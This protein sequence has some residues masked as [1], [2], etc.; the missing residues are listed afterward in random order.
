MYMS[1]YGKLDSKVKTRESRL[2]FLCPVLTHDIMLERPHP[3]FPWLCFLC[4]PKAKPMCFHPNLQLCTSLIHLKTKIT[5]ALGLDHSERPWNA[6]T[7]PDRSNLSS[8]LSLA[9]ASL[10]SWRI[11]LSS[12]LQWMVMTA[13][14]D[15]MKKK[16][17]KRKGRKD[18]A[19]GVFPLPWEQNP[20]YSDLEFCCL[21]TWHGVQWMNHLHDSSL[22]SND[23]TSKRILGQLFAAYMPAFS[24]TLFCLL[25]ISAHCLISDLL[26]VRLLLLLLSLFPFLGSLLLYSKFLIHL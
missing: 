9:K 2:A 7:N 26:T 19:H 22:S 8:S 12:D 14:T 21:R 15:N 6:Q 17:E 20:C 4:L 24:A 23:I 25:F 10:C 1:I 11:E 18:K 5:S 13:S 16:R 3:W